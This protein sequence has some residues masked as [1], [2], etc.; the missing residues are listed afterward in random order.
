MRDFSIF[1]EKH[2]KSFRFR[3]RIQLDHLV[4]PSL[5]LSHRHGPPVLG[6]GA[7]EGEAPQ[8]RDALI[9][10]VI[11]REIRD[12]PPTLR[13]VKTTTIRSESSALGRL[14]NFRFSGAPL[15]AHRE[16]AVPTLERAV[17]LMGTRTAAKRRGDVEKGEK[18]INYSTESFIKV[19]TRLRD[20]ASCLPVS[21]FTQPRAIL[22]E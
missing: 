16:A 20:P 19:C 15:S 6:G 22:F 12:I 21:E 7:L 13:F 8:R 4:E 18:K 5:R 2:V 11:A 3:C 10:R 14:V 9:Q 17:S 1:S